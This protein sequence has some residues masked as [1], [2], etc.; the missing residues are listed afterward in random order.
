M[1]SGPVEETDRG[2]FEIENGES[3]SLVEVRYQRAKNVTDVT[4][5][6]EWSSD[7]KTWH[8]SGDDNGSTTV[9]ITET[10]SSSTTDLDLVTAQIKVTD[11][12]A[13]ERIFVRITVR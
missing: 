3:D 9:T 11:G 13:P 5:G 4:G 6:L 12:Q 2:V 8:E 7:L 1:K 10:I